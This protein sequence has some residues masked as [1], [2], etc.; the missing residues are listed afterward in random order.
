[1]ILQP[2]LRVFTKSSN[3]TLQTVLHTLFLPTP[4]KSGPRPLAQDE[5]ATEILKPGSLY[6]D[7][8]VV[9]LDLQHIALDGKEST[10]KEKASTG[11]EK[12][13]MNVKPHDDGELGGEALGRRVWENFE[14]ALKVWEQMD[15]LKS[16]SSTSNPN[17]EN[18]TS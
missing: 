13:S 15:P 18:A 1:M 17:S 10:G 8:S 2:L 5:L 4:F 3:S 11:K 7:C 6:A 12:A 16:D 9:N 14:Q